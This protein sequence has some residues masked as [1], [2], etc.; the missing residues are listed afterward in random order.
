M[1]GVRQSFLVSIEARDQ[2]GKGKCANYKWVAPPPGSYFNSTHNRQTSRIQS[3]GSKRWD[4]VAYGQ[5]SG[6]W[7]WTFT[8]DYEYL[9][10]LLFAFESY[11]V[12][13]VDANGN[14]VPEIIDSEDDPPVPI[15]NPNIRGYKYSFKKDNAGKVPSFTVRRKILNYMAG[16]PTYSDE[17]VE[18]R[19]CVC[20][21]FRFNK[22][23]ASSQI[24]VTMTGFYADEKMITGELLN[25]DY[26]PYNGFLSE[27][28]C[29]YVSDDP[30]VSNPVYDY[31]ANTDNLGVSVENNA[32]AV[33][34][35]CSPF[36]KNYYEGLSDFSFTTSCYST[37]PDQ[38]KRRLYYGGYKGW[39]GSTSSGVL[40]SRPLAKGM[41]PIPAIKLIAYSGSNRN[42]PSGSSSSDD[43]PDHPTDDEVAKNSTYRLE[44]N[45]RDCVIKSMTWPKGNGGKI[46]DS[47]S[48]AE[49]KDISLDVYIKKAKIFFDPSEAG[50]AHSVESANVVD[51][52][53]RTGGCGQNN[54]PS[55]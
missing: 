4:T 7:E 20:K 48:S 24:S 9:T 43:E 47:I 36:A 42:P 6:Q 53:P 50:V 38:Y 54:D 15:P 22:T 17:I 40:T 29:M 45:I 44:F 46:Q 37:N 3:T 26:Q 34:A 55:D 33:Y 12:S 25:T 31:V 2:F 51:N 10:P 32:G 27:W 28:M 52:I 35:V 23:D 41:R 49:C 8:L 18:L 14:V 21:S 11:T 16:G 30:D 39:T 19:G 5:L 13:A 1:T